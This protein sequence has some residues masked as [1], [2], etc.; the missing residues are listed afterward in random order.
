MGGGI[1]VLVLGCAS[2]CEWVG[3]IDPCSISVNF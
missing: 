3:G 1:T 2:M